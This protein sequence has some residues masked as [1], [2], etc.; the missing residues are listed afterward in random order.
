MSPVFHL[1]SEP[2][3]A[4]GIGASHYTPARFAEDG[5][6]H[7]CADRASALAV[8]RDYFAGATSAVLLL[9]LD[10][11]RLDARL[12]FEAPAPLPG[13]PTTHLASAEKFPHVYGPIALRAIAGVGRLERRGD[14]FAWPAGFAP[15]GESVAAALAARLGAGEARGLAALR[16]LRRDTSRA[17]RGAPAR[18]VLEIGQSLVA[19]GAPGARVLGSELVR[20]HPTALSALRAADARRLAGRL[21]SWSD[22]D[23]FGCA[24]SG[25][26]FRDGRL[27]QSEILRWTRSRDLFWRRAALVS[28][29]PLNVRAQGG[30]GDAPRTLRICRALV[31]D[32]EDLVVKALSWALRA[33]A[34]RD[35]AAVRRFVQAHRAALAPRVLREVGNKL[36]TGRKNP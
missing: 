29:V 3:L 35:P 13:A 8:A 25:Q 18:L 7:C 9:E 5:F 15:L 6:V 31:D 32:R 1:V 12:V 22:V 2:E 10:P 20:H 23:V 11:A 24:I 21:E 26:A 28:T 34:E 30:S 27:A 36:R 33:L 17:L 19:S 14:G 4:A 16:R